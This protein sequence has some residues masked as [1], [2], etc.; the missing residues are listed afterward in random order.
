[1]GRKRWLTINF[2]GDCRTTAHV[3]PIRPLA[4]SHVLA[5]S[6]ANSRL[7]RTTKERT[8]TGDRIS[9]T[10]GRRQSRLQVLQSQV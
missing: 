6:V 5:F 8:S 10:G 4:F 3:P 9:G 2:S 7:A 1:M